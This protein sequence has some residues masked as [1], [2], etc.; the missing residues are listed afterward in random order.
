MSDY[1]YLTPFFL[2]AALDWAVANKRD[3]FHVYV[4]RESLTCPFITDN[5]PSPVIVLNI[6]PNAVR[7]FH[8][9]DTGFS[10]SAKVQGQPVDIHVAIQGLQHIGMVYREKMN[11]PSWGTGTAESAALFDLSDLVHL[12]L[13]RDGIFPEYTVPAKAPAKRANHLRVVK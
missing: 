12:D 8:L 5:D 6:H 3:R 13:V 4:S 9:D 1:K 11:D 2:R 10:M 7:N